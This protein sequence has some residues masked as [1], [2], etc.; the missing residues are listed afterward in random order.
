MTTS[1]I[2]IAA[3]VVE[4][5]LA[6]AQLLAQ[7]NTL[8]KLF[9]NFVA[10]GDA[11]GVRAVLEHPQFDLSM[12]TPAHREHSVIFSVVYKG[13]LEI[14]RMLLEKGIRPAQKDG[15]L[16]RVAVDKSSEEKFD[17]ILQLLIDYKV[18]SQDHLTAALAFAINRGKLN[19]MQILLNNGADPNG[20]ISV[21]DY[22]HV[23]YGE[24][25]RV[26]RAISF[27][28]YALNCNKRK[29]DEPLLLET[30]DILL[31]AGLDPFAK[32]DYF[33]NSFKQSMEDWKR[34][35]ELKSDRSN[36]MTTGNLRVTEVIVERCVTEENAAKTL[37]GIL[38]AKAKLQAYIDLITKHLETFPSNIYEKRKFRLASHDMETLDGLEERVRNWLPPTTPANQNGMQEAALKAANG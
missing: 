20:T 35:F 10:A 13:H 2:N 23:G 1:D 31:N 17:P 26:P 16:A 36:R 6:A 38:R 8:A 7:Q 25:R 27:L 37:A 30:V 24:Q 32:D 14:L 11:E 28:T 29:A 3:I 12:A 19:T 18:V 21:D 15:N 5:K 33:S 4:Q 22:V 34:N 9:K